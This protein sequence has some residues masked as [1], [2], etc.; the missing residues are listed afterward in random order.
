[1]VHVKFQ[2]ALKHM[3]HQYLST[4]GRYEILCATY[5]V[6]ISHYKIQL[7]FTCITH[8]VHHKLL[9]GPMYYTFYVPL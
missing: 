7:A 4:T 1:M 9:P 5:I 2:V 6:H 8:S 3:C